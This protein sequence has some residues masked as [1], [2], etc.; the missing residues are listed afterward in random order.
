VTSGIPGVLVNDSV[1][2]Q[3]FNSTWSNFALAFA[4][5]DSPGV[6]QYADPDVQEAIAGYFDCGCGPWPTAYQSVYFSAPPQ[7]DF[8]ASFLAE[9]Q[10]KDYSQQPIVVDAV[11]TQASVGAAWL[12][13]YLVSYNAGP[14]LLSANSDSPAP[15]VPFDISVVG[16]QLASFFQTVFTTGKP[17]SNSWPQSGSIEQETDRILSGLAFLTQNNLKETLSYTP[18][19]SSRAFA[20]TGGDIMCGEI[21]SH[22]VTTSA[23]SA[24]IVQ[25]PDRS[26]FGQEL[27]A[28]SYS[29]V[30]AASLRDACW[31]V[32]T[33]GTATPLSFLGGVYSRVGA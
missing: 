27:A 9:V 33:S 16:S 4:T 11:F 8:P 7:S 31:Y 18:G 5:G 25:P 15:T 28:G 23:D 3:V 26:T 6:A 30:T 14:D 32:S 24:P 12:V 1:A 2:Q 29:S 22:S 20:A 17:P 21:R 10:E 13:S 19:P